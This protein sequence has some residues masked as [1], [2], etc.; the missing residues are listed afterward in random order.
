MGRKLLFN[1]WETSIS[2]LVSWCT[3]VVWDGRHA[4]TLN[5][6][7][8]QTI[9]TSVN[10]KLLSISSVSEWNTVMAVKNKIEDNITNA[11]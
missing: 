2:V 11:K 4:K 10:T 3:S 1:K 9:T 7:T 5:Q 6:L 8:T